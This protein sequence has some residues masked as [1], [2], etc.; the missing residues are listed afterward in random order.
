MLNFGTVGLRLVRPTS[1]KEYTSNANSTHC[2]IWTLHC[3]D[4]DKSGYSLQQTSQKTTIKISL[5][6]WILSADNE[7]QPFEQLIIMQWPILW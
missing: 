7:Q 1:V 3:T 5:P 6:T 4:C 2:D